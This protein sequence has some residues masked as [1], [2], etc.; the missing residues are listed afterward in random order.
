MFLLGYRDG[1]SYSTI[2][3]MSFSHLFL[4]V[5]FS[6]ESWDFSWFYICQVVLDCILDTLNITFWGSQSHL[7]PLGKCWC[8]VI[9]YHLSSVIEGSWVGIGLI[10]QHFWLQ[11]EWLWPSNVPE[12]ISGRDTDIRWAIESWPASLK[13]LSPWNMM[14]SAKSAMLWLYFELLIYF[15]PYLALY[16]VPFKW[17]NLF[18]SSAIFL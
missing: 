13:R 12:K 1:I 3:L 9:L 15:H 8:S 18:V 14:G 4:L 5:T 7:N 16:P 10:Y 17:F 2:L 11:T 6:H